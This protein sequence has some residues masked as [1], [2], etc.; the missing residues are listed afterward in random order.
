MRDPFVVSDR[1]AAEAALCQPTLVPH[2]T[3]DT[4][5]GATIRLRGAMA[6]FSGPEEHAA[7][8]RDVE[9][10]I[11]PLHPAEARRLSESFARTD[12]AAGA[13]IDVVARTVPT[14]VLAE[15]LGLRA[16]ADVVDQVEAMVR[17]IGRG[18]PA[19]EASDA[20]VEALLDAAADHASGAVAVLSA[21]Y[22]NFDATTALV[23]VT[24]AATRHG[25]VPEPAVPR[26][27]RV[28]TA[29]LTLAG[30]ELEPGDEVIVEIAAAGLPFGHGPHH[31]PGRE[32]AEHIV[33]GI[34]AAWAATGPSTAD[35][36]GS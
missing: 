18:E 20:A 2:G 5:T 3:D 31:C 7:R 11:A 15:M 19:D 24:V 22:Q 33:D 6:R 23:R 35:P 9:A 25:G 34:V 30:R 29:A 28:A 36:V 21:L 13:P 27:R 16:E 12:L 26:T 32:L 17:V 14:L 8:R 1:D 4:S 10:A